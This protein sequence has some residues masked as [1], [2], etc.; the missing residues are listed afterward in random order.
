MKDTLTRKEIAKIY[1][2]IEEYHKK[3]LE[4]KGVKMPKLKISG[5]YTKDALILIYLA[6]NYPDVKPITKTQLTK[7]L[8]SNNNLGINGCKTAILRH[9]HSPYRCGYASLAFLVWQL[10]ARLC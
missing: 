5:K 3:Y 9:A 10:F 4:N 8:S 7:S 6:Q 1:K 2:T